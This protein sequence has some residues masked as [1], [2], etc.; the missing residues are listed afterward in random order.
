MKTKKKSNKKINIPKQHK[1]IH[2]ILMKYRKEIEK[3]IRG[4][5]KRE[6]KK[7]LLNL[8]KDFLFLDKDMTSE[9][10]IKKLSDNNSEYIKNISKIRAGS[11]TNCKCKQC[12]KLSKK[13]IKKKKTIK[14]RKISKVSRLIYN[15]RQKLLKSILKILGKDVKKNDKILAQLVINLDYLSLNKVKSGSNLEKV[16]GVID[17]FGI[18]DWG[19]RKLSDL[20]GTDSSGLTGHVGQFLGTAVS[21]TGEALLLGE[22]VNYLDYFVNDTIL[23]NFDS[24]PNTGLTD[25][26]GL[27]LLSPTEATMMR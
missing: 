6:Q 8:K 11:Q 2:K 5:S 10:L 23:G 4:K 9:L 17:P 15:L 26:T 13:K 22:T 19:R 16:K 25:F 14:N 7:I 12:K 24:C 27:P 20:V 3:L 18:G 21:L 1:V